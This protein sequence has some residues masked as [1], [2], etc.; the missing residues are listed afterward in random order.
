MKKYLYTLAI[1]LSTHLAYGKA[2]I[3]HPTC[4]VFI[5]NF[6]KEGL[7]VSMNPEIPQWLVERGYIPIVVEA[8]D[9]GETSIGDLVLAKQETSIKYGVAK[10]SIELLQVTTG[11]G[12]KVLA[13]RWTSTGKSLSL[14]WKRST[15]SAILQ[16]PRC[17]ITPTQ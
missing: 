10:I 7:N 16:L 1:G 12:K 5:P 9:N 17:K 14:W 13:S 3:Q 6:G 2:P 4:Q 11:L 8:E 15:R